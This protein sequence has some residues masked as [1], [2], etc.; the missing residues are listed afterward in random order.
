MYALHLMIYSSLILQNIFFSLPFLFRL[1]SA[2]TST[3]HC[4]Y[5]MYEC[6]CVCRM[7]GICIFVSYR[8]S[9]SFV[10][11][12]T[13]YTYYTYIRIYIYMCVYL[14]CVVHPSLIRRNWETIHIKLF[15]K[16]STLFWSSYVK[17]KLN[18]YY[19]IRI[20]LELN[21]FCLREFWICME[22]NKYLVLN[23]VECEE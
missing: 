2:F 9:S 21:C 13:H 18:K 10:W 16:F 12:S 5:S 15:Q 8:I 1:L 22:I 4:I 17:L 23:W 19:W 20:C 11:I 14:A 7:Y 3:M 6:V